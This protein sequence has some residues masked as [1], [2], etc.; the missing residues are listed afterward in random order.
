MSNDSLSSEE[1]ILLNEKSCFSSALTDFASTTILNKQF[2]S[3]FELQAY[4][5]ADEIDLVLGLDFG[6][7]CTKVV[8]MEDAKKQ[9]WAIP[10][11][12]GESAYLLPSKVFLTEGLYSLTGEQE[13]SISRLK[14]PMILE[15]IYKNHLVDVIA[16]LALVVRYSR[17]WFLQ[18]AASTFHGFRFNWHY[19]I[20]LPASNYDNSK[21][22]KVFNQ[23]LH[24]AVIAAN[25][26][27]ECIKRD[28][29]MNTYNL[30]FGSQKHS[31]EFPVHPDHI[32]TFPEISAQL[33]GYVN[34]DRWDRSRPKFMLVDIGGGTVDAAIVNVLSSENEPLKYVYLK[35]G[36]RTLGVLLLH[37]RRLRWIESVSEPEFFRRNLFQTLNQLK[38]NESSQIVPET[39]EQYLKHVVWPNEIP[40]DNEFNR[41]LGRFLREDILVPVK[42]DID[43][44]REQWKSLQYVLC[45]GGSLHP[46][47]ERFHK[48]MNQQSS[49]HVCLDVV[50]IPK[51]DNFHAE[52][53]N[54]ENFHRLSVAYGL[55]HFELGKFV[56][57]SAIE[58]MRGQNQSLEISAITKDQV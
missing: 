54:D 58:P 14:L 10:F 28:D 4:E 17:A 32:A 39:V 5:S 25:S 20:G 11:V 29:V 15:K 24:C 44:E 21:L 40:I 37:A 9:A 19:H 1:S 35:S 43:T 30:Y 26:N 3:C 52:G 48:G 18:N 22:V 7:S 38:K 34:S 6:T 23:A 36:V 47:Y 46:L 42:R 41:E 8:I 53:V 27:N 51:P 2:E 12:S 50:S 49:M 56:S 13:N 31:T 45:G 16:Y 55:A 33:H 57:E